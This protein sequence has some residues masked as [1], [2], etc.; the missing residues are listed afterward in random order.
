ML[1]SRINNDL[2]VLGKKKKKVKKV[3]K[4]EKTMMVWRPGKFF[5]FFFSLFLFH[6][7]HLQM[8]RFVVDARILSGNSRSFMDMN[9]NEMNCPSDAA[10]PK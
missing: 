7:N 9:E 1:K 2:C 8:P 3:K 10:G 4:I 5:D 6:K